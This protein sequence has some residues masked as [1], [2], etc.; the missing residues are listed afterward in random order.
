MTNLST[1][2]EVMR[3]AALI[4]GIIIPIAVSIM[5]IVEVRSIDHIIVDHTVVC[6]TSD[7]CAIHVNNIWYRIDGVIDMDEMI[8]D[9]YQPI[10]PTIPEITI[11]IPIE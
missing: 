4:A 9:K 6:I 8:P 3:T 5:A 11:D 10:V 2:G 1:T 7:T